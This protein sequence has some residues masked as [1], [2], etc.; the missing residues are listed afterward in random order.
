MVVTGE[1]LEFASEAEGAAEPVDTAVTQAGDEVEDAVVA[2][3]SKSVAA[4]GLVVSEL[5]CK[6]SSVGVAWDSEASFGTVS[7]PRVGFVFETAFEAEHMV[8]PCENTPGGQPEALAGPTVAEA[9]LVDKPETVELDPFAEGMTEEWD[10]SGGN[11]F[12][13]VALVCLST[14]GMETEPGGIQEGKVEMVVLPVDAG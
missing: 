9:E 4:P 5:H 13:F 14:A 6:V 1:K 3:E 10:A 7:E 12:D 8:V 11:Q 2:P